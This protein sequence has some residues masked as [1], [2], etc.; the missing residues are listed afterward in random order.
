MEMFFIL[1]FFLWFIFLCSSNQ[2]VQ[3]KTESAQDQAASG[4]AGLSQG[5]CAERSHYPETGARPGAGL[6]PLAQGHTQRRMLS[7]S[8][9]L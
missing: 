2:E 4:Q 5:D 9:Y 1:F 3:R 7:E 8:L 6:Q